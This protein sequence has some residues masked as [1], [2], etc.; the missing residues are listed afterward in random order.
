MVSG[1]SWPVSVTM[2]WA[3]DFSEPPG[4]V[5]NTTCEPSGD[6]AHQSS[7]AC[8]PFSAKVSGSISSRSLPCRPLRTKSLKVWASAGR[9]WV[10]M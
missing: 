6:D 5:P 7:E 2:M 4:E 1:N 9:T 8:E 3:T 10:K